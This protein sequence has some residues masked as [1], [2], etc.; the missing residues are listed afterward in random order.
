MVAFPSPGARGGGEVEPQGVGGV[1]GVG[2]AA[3]P[4]RRAELADAAAAGGVVDLAGA[5]APA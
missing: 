4:P 5:A 1:H 3:G 2:A